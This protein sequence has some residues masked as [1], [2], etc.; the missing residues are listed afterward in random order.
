MKKKELLAPAGN[1]ESLVQAVQNGA[2]AV[3][4]SGKKFGARAFAP[5]FSEEELVE[6]IKYC[7]LY[8]VKIYVTVNTMIYESEIEEC[9]HYIRFLHQNNVDAVIL[10]DLGLMKCIREKFPNLEIHAST[11]M[12]NHNIE[13]I[14]MLEKLGIKRIVLARELTLQEI[15]ALETNLELEVFIHGALCISYSGQCLFSSLLLNRSGNRG[16]CAGICRLP[17]T[18]MEDDK[19]IKVS[20][21]YLLSPKELNTIDHFEEMMESNIYSFKIEGRMK[22]PY[23]VG[24]ITRLYRKLMD[25]YS[26]NSSCTITEE[27]KKNLLVLYN[28]GFTSGHLFDEKN[29]DFMNIQTPN[30][31]GIFLGNVLNITKNK[32]KIK[33]NEDL[34]QEDGIRFASEDKGIVVNYLYNEKGLLINH[35]KKGDIVFVDNKIHLKT[36]GIVLKTIDSVLNNQLKN[37]LE[38]KIDITCAVILKLGKKLSLAFSDGIN[39]VIGYGSIVEKAISQPTEKEI[40]QKK[41]DSL[42]NTPFHLKQIE[43]R[44]DPNIFVN[45]GEIKRIRRELLS[46]LIQKRENQIPHAF[47]EKKIVKKE[48]QKCIKSEKINLHALV[49]TEEQLV[50]CLES[51]VDSIYTSNYLLY[52]KYKNKG[53]IFLK[54]ERVKKYFPEMQKE[55]LLVEETGSFY[56]Y[57]SENTIITDYS[58][59]IANSFSFQFLENNNVDRITLSVEAKLHDIENMVVNIKNKNKIEVYLYGRP[60]VMITKYCP[61]QMLVSKENECNVCKNNKRYYLKDRN[62]KLY[63]ILSN[64]SENHLTHIYYYEPIDQIALLKSYQ[65]MGIGHFRVEFLEESPEQ[66]KSIISKIKNVNF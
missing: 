39:T 19:K 53:N 45:V 10:Q 38:R 13:Q 34:H 55:N 17:F 62:E 52:Q 49:T 54:L 1:Y 43:I 35:A 31:Q 46:E 36:E 60:E 61:L 29:E 66:T 48:L 32:I 30:H 65:N 33:L 58:F 20:G 21:D 23:Y 56:K 24:F 26:A 59:N 37:I 5:N 64:K 9:I 18:L 50:A 4:L 16:S 15:N 7:H 28:R 11:Q 42:G 47:L 44:N 12:H 14:K 25:S 40:I 6:A 2:D 3:Y 41:I 51:K 57:N 8:D 22:S 63:P 27:E